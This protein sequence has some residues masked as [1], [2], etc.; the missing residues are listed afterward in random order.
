[1]RLLETESEL[2]VEVDVP[3]DVAMP[4]LAAHLRD[5]VLTITVPRTQAGA[6]IQA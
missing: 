5:G 2:V 4:Q 1:V 3:A 6:E